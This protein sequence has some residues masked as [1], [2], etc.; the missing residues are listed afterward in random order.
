M[1]QPENANLLKHLK[2]LVGE[3]NPFTTPEPLEQ[4]G[5]YIAHQFQSMGLAVSREEVPFEGITSH[6]IFG[7]QEGTDPSAGTFILGAHYDSVQ[8]TPGADDNASAVA[9]LLEVARCLEG[10]SVKGSILFTAF[11]L[12]EYG[13][14][15]SHQMAARIKESGDPIITGMIS[16]EMLGY[17]TREPGSQTYPPYVDPS[18][19]PDTG[20]FIAVVGNEPSQSLALGLAKALK[21]TTPELGVETLMLPG[22]ADEFVEVRLSDH[23]PFWEHDFKAAMLTDT[24]FFRNPHYHQAT[25][26]LETLDIDFI[27]DTC[28]GLVAYLQNPVT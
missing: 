17:R 7:L 14:I 12:E 24:A 6:N 4:A 25:D 19:Y 10:T 2:T 16:L 8:G 26:T 28:A 3:R 5:G 9:A 1:P 13:F 22:R 23:C 27:R 21:Q 15:G 20:D 18:Q 11:T